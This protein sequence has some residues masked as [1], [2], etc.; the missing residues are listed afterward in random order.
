MEALVWVVDKPHNDARQNPYQYQRGHV[1]VLRPDGWAWSVRERTDPAWRIIR[2]AGAPSDFQELIDSERPE[3]SPD[4]LK[5]TFFLDIAELETKRPLLQNQVV[6]FSR[7]EYESARRA[8][9]KRNAFV[10]G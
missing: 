2:V 7:G 8:S 1:I 10:V 4:A 5:R 6:Q 3:L 9:Q